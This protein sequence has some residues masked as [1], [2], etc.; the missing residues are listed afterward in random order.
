MKRIFARSTTFKNFYNGYYDA[1]NLS[2]EEDYDDEEEDDVADE[3]EVDDDEESEHARYFKEEDDLESDAGGNPFLS[4]TI[5]ELETYLESKY[6]DEQPQ[7]GTPLF[8]KL[9][10]DLAYLALLIKTSE[11]QG[12]GDGY[13]DDDEDPYGVNENWNRNHGDAANAGVERSVDDMRN[14][15]AGIRQ[16]FAK[17]SPEERRQSDSYYRWKYSRQTSPYALFDKGDDMTPKEYYQRRGRGDDQVEIQSKYPTDDDFDPRELL[18][19][20]AA[21]EKTRDALDSASDDQKPALREKLDKIQQYQKSL[22]SKKQA[23]DKRFAE[24]YA[25]NA[26]GIAVNILSPD[27]DG[28]LIFTLEATIGELEQLKE[29]L[30]NNQWLDAAKSKVGRALTR[31]EEDSA[32]SDHLNDLAKQGVWWAIN[33][34]L[35]YDPNEGDEYD[36]YDDEPAVSYEGE[37]DDSVAYQ[38]DKDE[39]KESS[40]EESDAKGDEEEEPTEY[41]KKKK[42]TSPGKLEVAGFD[43]DDDG[44][45]EEIEIE[46]DDSLV[47]PDDELE[48]DVDP[49][50]ELEDD[51]D[52]VEVEQNCRGASEQSVQYCEGAD[53]G[54]GRSREELLSEIETLKNRI[55]GL[56]NAFNLTT[57]KVVSAER[58]SRLHDLRERFLFDENA[59][60][61]NC[62]YS[63]MSDEQFEKRC[64][65]IQTN[66]RRVPTGIEVPPGLVTSAPA[67]AERPG[68][69][70]YSKEASADFERRVVERAETYAAQGIYKP[71][72]EIRA[73]IA[74]E[75]KQS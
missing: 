51:G 9:S 52:G 19:A 22:R 41:A 61:E 4:K 16:E 29:R 66:Y 25:K 53:C 44:D 46:P 60:R 24:Q 6:G 31:E 30:E 33:P 17:M 74:A 10:T 67:D 56:E 18:N 20:N 70:Q 14:H 37:E 8:N 7:P 47:D 65:E 13:E 38:A 48:D 75:S 12:Y 59:E 45:D 50:S 23:R 64:E 35:D 58:Y 28:D 72:D 3:E 34:K 27:Y 73:E 55:A 5:E 32:W 68:A 57:E 26:A 62:R 2:D 15:E 21:E 63:K 1:Y 54:D 49:D 42:T 69:V 43:V 36:A 39:E 40:D 71:S 11:E